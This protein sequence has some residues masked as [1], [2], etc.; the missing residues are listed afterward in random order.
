MMSLGMKYAQVAAI[1]AV[2][3]ASWKPRDEESLKRTG[4][5]VGMAMVDDDYVASCRELGMVKSSI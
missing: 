1:E 4:V 2:L 3:D 5:A